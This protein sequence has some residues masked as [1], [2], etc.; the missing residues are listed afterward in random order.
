MVQCFLKGRPMLGLT[1]VQ[2]KVMEFIFNHINSTGMPPTIREITNF[3]QWKAIGSAQDVIAVLRKKQL[4]LPPIPGKSR[5]IVPT[6]DVSDIFL[7]YVNHK[8]YNSISTAI[9][10][11]KNHTLSTT[12]D[13]LT[14]PLYGYVKAGI[15]H[16]SIENSFNIVSF[17]TCKKIST[18]NSKFFALQVDGNSMINAGFLPEDIILVEEK[19]IPQDKDIVIASINNNESTLKRYAK[20]GSSLYNKHYEYLSMN[21]PDN[22][23]DAILIPENPEYQPIAFG[24]N[25]NDKIIGVVISLYRKNIF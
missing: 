9:N 11:Q 7:N 15:P 8:H 24:L 17:P 22:K 5:Q 6:Q 10:K 12:E 14:V 1:N 25:E 16:E 23:P 4:L 13:F 20:K 19:S 18:L 21:Y 3:F 2:F